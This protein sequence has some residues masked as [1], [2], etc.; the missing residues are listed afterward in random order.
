MTLSPGTG[1]DVGV[2]V[3]GVLYDFVEAL[4]HWLNVSTGRDRSTMPD[5]LVWG[6]HG[7][8]WGLTL[9]EFLRHYHEGVEAG[10]VFTHGSPYPGAREGL[11]ALRSLG[12]R[13]HVVTDRAHVGSPGVSEAATRAWLEHH[14][15]PH[16]TVLLSGDKTCIG[17]RVFIEDRVENARALAAAG[18]GVVLLDRPWNQHLEE[19]DRVVRACSWDEVPDLVE[20]LASQVSS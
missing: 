20:R 19:S 6:F 8:Q 10:V 14:S 5:A 7:K 16:D 18:T 15:L 3:D 9:E 2:D 4:R 13:L 1:V 11:S 17:A 12:H